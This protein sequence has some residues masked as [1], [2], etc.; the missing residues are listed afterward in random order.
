MPW[1]VSWASTP[2]NDQLGSIYSLLHTS[3]H[4]TKSSSFL[5][6]GAPD[7]PVHIGH[8]LFTVW[9]P[10]TSA[11]RWILQQSPVGSDRRQ[12]VQCTP[13]SPML[14]PKSTHCG[15]ISADYPGVPPDSPVHTRQA[16][17]T[18]R[19]TTRVLADCRLHG[20]LH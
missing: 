11:D 3:S 17:F 1:Y 16:L 10:A 12:T 6:T 4:W 19:C 8:T 9:C 7:S 15:H 20:F 2:P 14:H 13:D 5:L 18:V